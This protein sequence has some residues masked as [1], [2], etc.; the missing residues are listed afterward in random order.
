MELQKQ[1]KELEERIEELEERATALESAFTRK[2]G[3]PREEWDALVNRAAAKARVRAE[4]REQQK[5][6]S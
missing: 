6:Q 4:R 1:L 3:I 2:G 5:R